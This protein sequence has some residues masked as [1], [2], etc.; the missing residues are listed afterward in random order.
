MFIRKKI[1]TMVLCFLISGVANI[2]AQEYVNVYSSRIEKLIKPAFDAFTDET[3]VLVRYL[4]AKEAELQSRMAA[5]G[6]YTKAD[7]L[8]TVD[9]GNLWLAANK[10]LLQPIESRILDANVPTSVKDPE[11]RW[12]GLTIRARTIVYSKE[13][14]NPTQLSTYEALGDSMWKDRLCL[15]TSKKVYNKSLVATMIA[16]LGATKARSIVDGWVANQP[17]I[18]PKDSTLLKSIAAGKCD[19]GVVNTYYLGRILAKDANF[20]VGLF[21]ANQNEQGVHINISGAG[22]AK[23][24]KNKDN[25]IRLLEFL[26]SAKA[27]NLFAD[28]NYEYPVNPIVSPNA[29]L[30]QWWGAEFKQDQI[31][32][33]NAGAYQ[34]QAVRLMESAG[35]K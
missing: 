15:R 32:V 35:Y 17:I 19:V 2:W 33:A 11:G 18:E 28:S 8:I 34:A 23:Y 20:P 25:A 1:I 13:R 10:G 5:E 30:S 14:V 24:A 3:G 21:W 4:T 29:K 27:Q 7:V 12:Y 26:S 22:V 6:K 31:N 16:D 9:A